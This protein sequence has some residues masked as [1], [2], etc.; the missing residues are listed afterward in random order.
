MPFVC[1]ILEI[2]EKINDIE[3]TIGFP[4]ET[5]NV[6][7]AKFTPDEIVGLTPGASFSLPFVPFVPASDPFAVETA[8]AVPDDTLVPVD[9]PVVMHPEDAA[10]AA[11]PDEPSTVSVDTAAPAEVATD[12]TATAA[13]A[14]DAAATA[15]VDTGTPGTTVS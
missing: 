5:G 10:V 4:D 14:T 2:D 15:P 7:T 8:V 1:K 12:P 6:I 3:V 11:S 13:A 9:H